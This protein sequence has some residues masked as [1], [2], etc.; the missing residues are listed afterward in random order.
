MAEMNGAADANRYLCSQLV[1]LIWDGGST[2][3]NLEEIQAGSGV[4]ESDSEL[5]VGATVEIRHGTV[6]FAGAV[7]KAEEHVFGW[8]VT[9][10]F[11]PSTLWSIEQFRP[12]HLF[13]PE[14]MSGPAPKPI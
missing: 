12:D 4:L 3:A 9:V 1:T 14:A 13:D 5:A 11:S 6:C 7:T 10:E 2:V 8:R